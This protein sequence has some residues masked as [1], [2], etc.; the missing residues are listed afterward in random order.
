[1]RPAHVVSFALLALPLA[2][3]ASCFSI[4]SPRN[5][6]VYQSTVNPIDLSLPISQALRPRFPNH[7][8]VMDPDES[9]CTEVG[10]G[11]ASARLDRRG[12]GRSRGTEQIL[13]TSPLLR[14]GR[15]PMDP[16]ASLDESE[17]LDNTPARPATVERRGRAAATPRAR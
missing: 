4:Y 5:V 14:D 17:Y 7:H 2:A 1:M 12:S 13:E 16:S 11:S 8:L 3:S 9:A 15:S 10:A 6:L